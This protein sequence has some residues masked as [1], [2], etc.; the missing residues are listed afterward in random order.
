MKRVLLVVFALASALGTATA[1]SP[2]GPT[3]IFKV[4]TGAYDKVMQDD[5]ATARKMLRDVL[6]N[7]RYQDDARGLSLAYVALA[8]IE[9]FEAAGS[10]LPFDGT[11]VGAA[12]NKFESVVTGAS[13]PQALAYLQAAEQ[14]LLRQE[15][16]AVQA[17]DDFALSALWFEMASIYGRV[18][19]TTKLCGAL[20]KSLEFHLL[21]T[22]KHPGEPVILFG[23]PGTSEQFQKVI[24]FRKK[25]NQCVGRH[26]SGAEAPK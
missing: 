18:P 19:D 3:E 7:A 26:A 13:T 6:A 23:R 24:E 2:V 16:P 11:H 8:D 25:A 1:A 4:V 9:K 15:S 22:S 20:S 17:G 5:P 12:G 14:Q 21:G 10:P